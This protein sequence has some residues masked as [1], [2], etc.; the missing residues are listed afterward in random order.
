[1][2]K[3]VS[4]S[5]EKLARAF[6]EGSDARINGV[7]ISENPYEGK[8]ATSWVEGWSDVHNHWGTWVKRRCQPTPRPYVRPR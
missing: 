7:C 1:M 8:Q 2:R 6:N 3:F 5:T 4:E